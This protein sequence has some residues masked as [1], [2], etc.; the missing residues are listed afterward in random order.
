MRLDQVQVCFAGD[1]AVNGV[2]DEDLA[3]HR[4]GGDPRCQRDVAPEQV[5]ITLDDRPDV[6]ADAYLNRSLAQPTVAGFDRGS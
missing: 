6:D 5:T 3:A 1:G 2:A 4:L